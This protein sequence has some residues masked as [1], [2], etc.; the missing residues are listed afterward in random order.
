[1][2]RLG[3]T[4]VLDEID[5]EWEFERP[6]EITCQV[7]G[8]EITGWVDG[9]EIL[10]IADPGAPFSDGGFAFVCDEGL[11]T[12]DEITIKPVKRLESQ[13]T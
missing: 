7:S 13:R 1:M 9:K 3:G 8:A 12:S 5:F 10:R 11:I 2:K 4:E 6:Y